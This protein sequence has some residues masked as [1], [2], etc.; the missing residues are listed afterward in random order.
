MSDQLPLNFSFSFEKHPIHAF[1]HDGKPA[2][3]AQEVAAAVGI[4]DASKALR[5]SPTTERPADYEVI[6]PELLQPTG[7]VPAGGPGFTVK[8]G[9]GAVTILYESGLY[10]L[11]LRSNKP[12]AMRFT[13][14]VVR[15]VLPQI[16]ATGSYSLVPADFQF[17][18][19]TRP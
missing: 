15:D 17:D 6:S 19:I 2:W 14:W 5:D 10:A 9:T 8:P 12:A 4:V 3:I 13:R 7:K 16:R 1:L 18:S 11:V